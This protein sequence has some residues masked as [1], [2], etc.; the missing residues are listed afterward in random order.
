MQ[1]VYL[2]YDTPEITPSG[3]IVYRVNVMQ[4]TFLSSGSAVEPSQLPAK[5]ITKRMLTARFTARQ[6]LDQHN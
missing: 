1:T 6:I 4:L 5:K 3:E 2:V